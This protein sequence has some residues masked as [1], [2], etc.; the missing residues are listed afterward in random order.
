MANV[1]TGQ[2]T[3]SLDRLN[4][5]ACSY[6]EH[7]EEYKKRIVEL[8]LSTAIKFGWSQ[9]KATWNVYLLT[10]KIIIKR[11]HPI[12]VLEDTVFTEKDMIL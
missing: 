2:P 4:I 1:Y 12:I 8:L 10:N 5:T 6:S 9:G 11:N 7:K 3:G